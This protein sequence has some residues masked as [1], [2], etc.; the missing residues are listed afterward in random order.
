MI[1]ARSSFASLQTHQVA[2]TAAWIAALPF[3]SGYGLKPADLQKLLEAA[4][5]NPRHQLLALLQDDTV[6]G[7]AWLVRRGAFDRSA[8]LRLLAV[9]SD[10]QGKG[11]GRALMERAEAEHLKPEGLALLVTADNRP[12]REFYERL[13]YR[14]CG[15]IADYVR[16]GRRECMYFKPGR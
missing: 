16:Q 11:L 1:R 10:Q 2:K 5:A 12:A 8:Y 15:A 4:C 7:L 6:V 14:H 13:G 9:A 3:F